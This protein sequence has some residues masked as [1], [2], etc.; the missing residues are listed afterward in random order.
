MKKREE[1]EE[2]CKKLLARGPSDLEQALAYWDDALKGCPK[3][4][5]P[6]IY[7]LGHWQLG[8]AYYGQSM[9]SLEGK[10]ASM[11]LEAS[12]KHFDATLQV[13]SSKDDPFKWGTAA[14]GMGLAFAA[15]AR[16]VAKEDARLR[17]LM[18]DS[19]EREAATN[20]RALAVAVRRRAGFLT[21]AMDNLE[22]AVGAL[23]KQAYPAEHADVQVKV[24]RWQCIISKKRSV[25]M[26]SDDNL[27]DD[28]SGILLRHLRPAEQ[29]GA[30]GRR[31]RIQA[32][33]AEALRLAATLC[34]EQ[35]ANT[36]GGDAASVAQADQYLQEAVKD[37]VRG[38]AGWLAGKRLLAR[39]TQEIALADGGD[40]ALGHLMEAVTSC[41]PHRGK[42]LQQLHWAA[43]RLMHQRLRQEGGDAAEVAMS[44]SGLKSMGRRAL[45]LLGHA[46][47]GAQVQRL[48]HKTRLPPL[49]DA[50][51]PRARDEDVLEAED[52]LQKACS[53]L[54]LED[55]T[56][57]WAG[58]TAALAWCAA[59]CGDTAE[60][61]NLYTQPPDVSLGYLVDPYTAIIMWIP[62]NCK[63]SIDSTCED[64]PVGGA[65]LCCVVVYRESVG[66]TD[67]ND[68]DRGDA[69]KAAQQLAFTAV[70]V[71]SAEEI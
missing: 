29:A 71:L 63:T 13:C 55:S 9:E 64:L 42:A 34:L 36:M 4:R 51:T 53:V 70:D 49:P 66:G 28:Q 20:K 45:E 48:N 25:P 27:P 65:A 47:K 57:E 22:C 43:G 11:S 6:L 1:E 18:L 61:T 37:V 39:A 12:L 69:S 60:A 3:D 54:T 15:L 17:V 46:A 40:T 21:R 68:D 10:S 35:H 8:I 5:K 44:L 26:S 58:M 50:V 32:A 62:I 33:R 23:S 16:V 19:E 2:R 38:E 41:A 67:A 24:K 7:A 14:L 31:E 52:F 59:A 30:G 56:A